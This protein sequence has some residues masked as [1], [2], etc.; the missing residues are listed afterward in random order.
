VRI[1]LDDRPGHLAH[2]L[3]AVAASGANVLDIE[4][5]FPGV[6]A[7]LGQAQV[8]LL[9]ELRNP[10]HADDVT[11]AIEAAGYERREVSAGRVRMFEPRSR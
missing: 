4:Q 6:E 10:E 7:P 3:G 8:E 5:G 9:L 1:L 11:A 2:I